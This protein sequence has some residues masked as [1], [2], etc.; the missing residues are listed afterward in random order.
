MSRIKFNHHAFQK[1]L[2]LLGG[3]AFGLSLLKNIFLDQNPGTLFYLVEFLSFVFFLAAFYVSDKNNQ[4]LR[5]LNEVQ[6]DQFEEDRRQMS[7]KIDNLQE[8]V[9]AFEE[10]ENEA[11]RF[12]TY[13]EKILQKLSRIGDEAGDKHRLLYTL[14]EL[15]H[16]M[17]VILYKKEEPKGIFNVEATYGLS[18]EVTVDGFI[19]GGGLHGQAV[20][21]GVPTM[22][23]EIPESYF[24]V[25]T[26]LGKSESYFLY[27]LP[28]MQEEICIGLVELL[29]FRKSE[30]KELWPQ[31]MKMLV[32]QEIL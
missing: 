7:R 27:L 9:S 5:T 11:A 15:F 13:Q 30:V 24:E 8:I 6:K 2:F 32:E 12:A 16:G 26:A 25:E 10:K 23:E 14:G 28:V 20:A 4:Q 17:A 1:Y 31:V 18:E 21:D 19:A 22:V 29:T 3:I